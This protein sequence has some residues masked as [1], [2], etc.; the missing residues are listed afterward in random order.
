MPPRTPRLAK[1][2]GLA[3][4]AAAIHLA[5]Q[6]RAELQATLPDPSD[7]DLPKLIGER[8]EAVALEDIMGEFDI[9]FIG[10][11]L[12]ST[13][14]QKLA[15]YQTLIGLASAVPAMQVQIPWSKLAQAIIGDLLELPEA[16]AAVGT[17]GMAS[18]LAMMLARGGFGQS[19]GAPAPGPSG[20][21]T[22]AQGAGAPAL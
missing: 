1:P 20:A 4:S 10:S 5:R 13:R 22:E 2:K 8:P 9:R 15:A 21:I 18:G 7:E 14:Q 19:P 17:E 12:A 3:P 11:R 6:R 16:V